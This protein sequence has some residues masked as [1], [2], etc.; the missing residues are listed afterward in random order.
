[1]I[2]LDG[3]PLG[4]PRLPAVRGR[5]TLR[6]RIHQRQRLAEVRVRAAQVDRQVAPGVGVDEPAGVEV[7]FVAGVE[8]FRGDGLGVGLRGDGLVGDGDGLLDLVVFDGDCWFVS[9]GGE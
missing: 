1:M 8:P 2:L 9:W 4:R 3:N 5:Q 6:G 7:A